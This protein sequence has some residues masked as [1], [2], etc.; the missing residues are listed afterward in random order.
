MAKEINISFGGRKGDKHEQ[1]SSSKEK[2]LIQKGL[3]S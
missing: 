2:M 1:S 3:P